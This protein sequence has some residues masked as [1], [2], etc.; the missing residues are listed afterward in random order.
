MR[1]QKGFRMGEGPFEGDAV[2]NSEGRAAAPRVRQDIGRRCRPAK[3]SKLVLRRGGVDST[4]SVVGVLRGLRPAAYGVTLAAAVDHANSAPTQARQPP[5]VAFAA[6]SSRAW[7]MKSLRLVRCG[8]CW[9]FE[10]ACRH[11]LGVSGRGK[12]GGLD[13]NDSSSPAKSRHRP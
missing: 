9:K 7:P 6:R 4:R 12:V 13:S 2:A 5:A 8:P 10:M 11:Q 3:R 1:E